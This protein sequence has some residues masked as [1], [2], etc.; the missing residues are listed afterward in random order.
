MKKLFFLPIIVLTLSFTGSQRIIIKRLKN[1]KVQLPLEDKTHKPKLTELTSNNGKIDSRVELIKALSFVE[2]GGNP[3]AVGDTHLNLP[4]VGL[5][6][7][8]P[9][10]VRE[11]NRILKN[12]G[13]EKKFKNRDRKKAAESIEIFN[14][15]ADAYHLNSSFEKMARNW[16]GGPAGYKKTATIQYWKK[17]S[18]YAKQN[19]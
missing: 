6:Q 3:N 4:S 8:R 5:L 7:I 15:W 11:V 19:L 14:I 17:V 9:V 2:S 1:K 18:N 12:K 13:L 10:M 16:N